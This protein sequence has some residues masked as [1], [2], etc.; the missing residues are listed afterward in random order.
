MAS[1]TGSER[2]REFLARLADSGGAKTDN[3]GLSRLAINALSLL[4]L[5]A[6]YFVA[7]KLGLK[8]ASVH[9]SAT[10]VWPPTGISL[11]AFLM[12]GYRVWPG[13]FLG[14]LLVNITTAGSLPVCLGIAAG[15]TLEGIVGCYLLNRFAGG[16]RAFESAKGVLKFAGLAAILSTCVSA[17]F[18]ATSLSLG[19]FASWTSYGPILLT[20]WL[21]DAVSD[22]LMAPLLVLW[23]NKPQLKWNR[24]RLL[25]VVLLLIYLTIAG[26]VAFEGLIPAASRHYPLEFLCVPAL[27]WAAFRF[28][29][30]RA[31][32]ASCLLAGIAIHGTM[33][34]YGPF[35]QATQNE[36]L[37][38][39]LAYAG[40]MAV[41]TLL[42]ATVV[43]E[44]MRTTERIRQIAVTDPLT[45]LAN[46]RRLLEVLDAE[47][48]RS[49]RTGRPFALLL[50]DLDGLKMIND[51]LGHLI[52]SRALCRLAD[53]LRSQSRSIDTAARYGGDEF[54]VVMPEAGR[55]AAEQLALRIQGQLAGET[56][57]PELSVSV[58]A[59]VFPASGNTVEELLRAADAALY[60]RKF[61]DSERPSAEGKSTSG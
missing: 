60:S 31:Q 24:V 5:A 4:A 18:G 45:G 23:S 26:L 1:A 2:K 52:G 19:G 47:I 20:W 37:F 61:K 51:A 48:K 56:E 16:A 42:L 33:R 40:V 3:R 43:E 58:G 10:M 49:D 13:I 17:T 32:L 39:A 7:G 50:L 53:V 35:V 38:L 55:R 30:R 25:E 41:M 9:P 12:L 8:L 21:G 29:P 44:H 27:S 54:A 15:N 36:S 28:R 22:L 59:A 57:Y 34:G 46:Y 6:I 14:A 11:V